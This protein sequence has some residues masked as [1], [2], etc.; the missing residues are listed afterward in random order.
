MSNFI[1]TKLP[2]FA[3]L[4]FKNAMISSQAMDLGRGADPNGYMVEEIWQ[5]LARAKYLAWD[6]ESTLRTSKLQTLK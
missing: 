6:Q 4:A 3:V 5:S 1:I 2:E